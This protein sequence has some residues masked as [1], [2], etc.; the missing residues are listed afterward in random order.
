MLLL[1]SPKMRLVW[2]T[3]MSMF[4][5]FIDNNNRSTE[6][7]IGMLKNVIQDRVSDDDKNSRTDL[8]LRSYLCNME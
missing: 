6:R 3:A 1:Y 8:R 7:R 4:W 5:K 2:H